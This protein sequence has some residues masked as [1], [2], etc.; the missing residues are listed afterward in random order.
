MRRSSTTLPPTRFS[1]S[2]TCRKDYMLQSYHQSAECFEIIFN[3]AKFDALAP[4]LQAIIKYA[5]EASSADMSWKAMDRYS[6]DLAGSEGSRASRYTKT[7]DSVLQAQ[8]AAWDKVLAAQSAEP[9]LRQGGRKPE[10]LG[11]AR[12]RHPVRDGSRPEDGLRSLLQGLVRHCSAF[13]RSGG[14]WHRAGME[15]RI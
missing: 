9:V 6:K 4:E 5:A 7:P 8:L 13:P 15:G 2:P 14:R 1:A 11:Q 12:G 10:G 3:K